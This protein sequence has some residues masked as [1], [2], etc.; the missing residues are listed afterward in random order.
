[1]GF[2]LFKQINHPADH[3]LSALGFLDRTHLRTANS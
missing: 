1:V 3:R 2:R